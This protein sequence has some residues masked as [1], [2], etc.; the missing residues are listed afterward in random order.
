MQRR[1]LGSLVVVAV[2][3]TSSGSPAPRL[4]AEAIHA[5]PA[6]GTRVTIVDVGVDDAYY[7]ARERH[8]GRSCELA[9]PTAIV[10]EF[11]AADV[12]CDGELLSFAHVRLAPAGAAPAATATGPTLETDAVAAG[13]AVVIADV[14]EADAL[15]P[16]RARLLGVRC[17]AADELVRLDGYYAG[18]LSCGEERLSFMAVALRAAP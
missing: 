10:D 15:H 9:S 8:V 11:V 17:T 16:V 4:A 18:T 14:G 5:E 7:G 2:G 1:L 13:T 6:P 12:R 3:C